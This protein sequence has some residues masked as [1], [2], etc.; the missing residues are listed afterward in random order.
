M[1]KEKPKRN[2]TLRKV[3]L[4]ILAL[5]FLLCGFVF[6]RSLLTTRGAIHTADEYRAMFPD[7]VISVSKDGSVE[8]TPANLSDR[9]E[10]GIVFYVGAEINPDAYIP[11]LAR[12]A[13]QGYYCSIPKLTCNMAAMKPGAAEDVFQAHPEITSWYLAGHSMGGYT[14][15]GFAEDHFDEVDGLILLAAYTSRDF[16]TTDIPMLSI[17]G[18]TDSVL[19]MEHYI[20]CYSMNSSDFEEH[21]IAGGNHAQFGD[22]GKQPHDTEATISADSQQAQ[23]AEIIIDWLARHE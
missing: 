15:S 4:I 20:K 17:Y 8:I 16:S 12:L 11:L 6:A 18:D 10:I 7:T 22:Y 19:N 21:I 5:V 14:A 2:R 3:I 23:T 1:K 9:L 13:E